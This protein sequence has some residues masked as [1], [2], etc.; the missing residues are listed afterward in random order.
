LA[1]AVIGPGEASVDAAVLNLDLTGTT[2]LWVYL[3]G[4]AAG[5]GQL[6]AFYRRPVGEH[7]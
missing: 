6:L 2:G 4:L 3:A 1:I 7:A 5:A